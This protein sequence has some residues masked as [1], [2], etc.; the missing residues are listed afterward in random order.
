MLNARHFGH[1]L[2][3]WMESVRI[4]IGK[5]RIKRAVLL[6]LSNTKKA[7]KLAENA[8]CFVFLKAER[9]RCSIIS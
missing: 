3:L 5:Y 8:P 2:S 6:L 9:M 4:V 1:H 7:D